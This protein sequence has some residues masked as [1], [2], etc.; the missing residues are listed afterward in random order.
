MKSRLHQVLLGIAAAN[1]LAQH[2][3]D[4][5]STEKRI[6][7]SKLGKR[8]NKARKKAAK[9]MRQIEN[10]HKRIAEIEKQEGKPIEQITN[11]NPSIREL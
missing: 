1:I 11:E 4:Y 2:E 6:L 9:K 8:G 3:A 7:K 10:R 5:S